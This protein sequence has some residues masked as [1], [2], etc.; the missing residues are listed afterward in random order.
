MANI[1]IYEQLILLTLK[2][3]YSIK[4]LQLIFFFWL[5]H[6]VSSAYTRTGH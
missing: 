1:I 2:L 5:K 4:T 3:K 6:D